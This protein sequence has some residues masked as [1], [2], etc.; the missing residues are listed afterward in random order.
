MFDLSGALLYDEQD[1]ASHNEANGKDGTQR[2][3]NGSS[4]LSIRAMEGSRKGEGAGEKWR[5]GE[6]GI[7]GELEAKEGKM[8][9]SFQLH[10]HVLE[11]ARLTDHLQH[12]VLQFLKFSSREWMA[13][14]PYT[15]IMSMQI[16]YYIRAHTHTRTHTHMHIHM[17]M[18]THTHTHIHTHTQPM[19]FPAQE[20]TVD[21][22]IL[23]RIQMSSEDG[24]IQSIDIGRN[25]VIA[26][27]GVPSLCSSANSQERK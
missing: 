26:L 15:C 23:R 9:D 6:G 21:S 2:V 10:V 22:W 5:G 13:E 11:I 25:R 20:L 16:Q 18:H 19:H 27:I 8:N 1:E 14:G 7:G 12:S 24:I 17:H 4:K 3:H